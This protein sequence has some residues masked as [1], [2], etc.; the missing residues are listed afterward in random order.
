MIAKKPKPG[1]SAMSPQPLPTVVTDSDSP[2]RLAEMRAAAAY[3]AWWTEGDVAPLAELLR[4]LSV[5]LSADARM[6]AAALIDRS[7]TR[8][9]GAPEQYLGSV[10]RSMVAEVFAEQERLRAA[11]KR[12]R[13]GSP[14][15][16]A[17][18][19]VAQR[20]RTTEGAVRGIVAKLRKAGITLDRWKQWG[21]PDWKPPR[22]SSK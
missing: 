21:R 7:L 4:D 22:K 11:P 19:L 3:S 9:P 17:I 15:E 16:L 13:G 2:A 18:H 6:F 20:R 5:E 10:E 12:S 8:R 14:Q 1:G